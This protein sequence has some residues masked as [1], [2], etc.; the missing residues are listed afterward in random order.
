MKYF[1][2][3]TDTIQSIKILLYDYYLFIFKSRSKF[4]STVDHY[5]A[6]FEKLFPLGL[7]AE[8]IKTVE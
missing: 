3:G 2:L 5:F 1:A 6:V 7:N 4:K 8:Y